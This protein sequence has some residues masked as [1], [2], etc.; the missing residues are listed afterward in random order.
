MQSCVPVNE[1][2]TSLHTASWVAGQFF[3]PAYLYPSSVSVFRDQPAIV[4]VRGTVI[5]SSSTTTTAVFSAAT[6]SRRQPNIV[7]VISI[8]DHQINYSR[9]SLHHSV[10]SVICTLFVV[11]T[12]INDAAVIG[13]KPNQPPSTNSLFRRYVKLKLCNGESNVEQFWIQFRLA[14]RLDQWP[15]EEQGAILATLLKGNARRLLYTDSAALT[16][17]FEFLSVQLIA[18]KFWC[19]S[20]IIIL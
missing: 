20:K 6:S 12:I 2:S 8:C 1:D 10:P 17:T 9:V 19:R 3:H 14:A 13:I 18:F 5:T 15:G 11:C 4:V 7:N 16:P